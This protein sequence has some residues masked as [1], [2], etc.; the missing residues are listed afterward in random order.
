MDSFLSK[1]G[2][3]VKIAYYLDLQL[4]VE[5]DKTRNKIIKI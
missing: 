2:A 3:K 5:V 1:R 4:I